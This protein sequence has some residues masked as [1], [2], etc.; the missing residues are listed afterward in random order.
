M[1]KLFVYSFWVLLCLP[2]QAQQNLVPNGDFE[3]YTGC[4]WGADGIDRYV[5]H[6]FTPWS[7]VKE[8]SMGSSDYFHECGHENFSPSSN[9]GGVQLPR[10]GEAYAGICIG[11]HYY[12]KDWDGKEYID[13]YREYLEVELS[14]FLQ[15]GQKYCFELWYSIAEYY[16]NTYHP[17]PL[18]VLLTD[19]LV[20]RYLVA[21]HY[22]TGNTEIIPKP[23]SSP[24]AHQDTTIT[25]L[26]TDHWF[27]ISGEFIAQ[28]GERYLTLGNFGPEDT[29][30][31]KIAYVYID[32]VSLW[33]CED[34]A[35]PMPELLV[36]YPNPANEEINFGFSSIPD[37]ESAVLEIFTRHGKLV[38]KLHLN[39]GIDQTKILTQHLSQG[40]YLARL[41][42]TT[43]EQAS[44]KFMVRH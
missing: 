27:K 37:N 28:G 5:L 38:E 13:E 24:L 36:V 1:R 20:K 12:R 41:I 32:D 21:Y 25:W 2:L 33:L 23:I 43:G 19:T 44:V 17:V 8:D 31:Y 6:W 30:T 39:S 15:Q 16:A 3:Q 22:T 7:L 34:E 11:Q 9:V 40:I 42:Y 26:D 18:G 14:K 4:P 29:V 35:E 10:S